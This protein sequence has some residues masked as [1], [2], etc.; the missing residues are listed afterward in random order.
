MTGTKLAVGVSYGW[1]KGESVSKLAENARVSVFIREIGDE[2]KVRSLRHNPMR[3][4]DMFTLITNPQAKGEG[5]NPAHTV[6][7]ANS[8][9]LS[10]Y[11]LP[12]TGHVTTSSLMYPTSSNTTINIRIP[13]PAALPS[14]VYLLWL[15]GRTL[16]LSSQ[17]RVN[18]YYSLFSDFRSL[19]TGFVVSKAQGASQYYI[20]AQPRTRRGGLYCHYH[21]SNKVISHGMTDNR[22]APS[23]VLLCVV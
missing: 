2:V 14:L 23:S 13:T 21:S 12:P 1:E 22:E 10:L 6:V 3:D 19:L 17:L 5:M 15:L 11:S 7:S 20:I 16:E 18:A 4:V 9:P 8:R